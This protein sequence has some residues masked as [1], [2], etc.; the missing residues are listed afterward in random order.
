MTFW[1]VF[2]VFVALLVVAVAVFVYLRLDYVSDQEDACRDAGGVSVKSYYGDRV[3]VDRD[4]LI[5]VKP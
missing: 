3:C 5:E 4:V 1:R 2:D